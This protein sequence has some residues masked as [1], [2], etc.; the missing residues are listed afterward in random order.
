[1]FLNLSV[2]GNREMLEL[3]RVFRLVTYIL[4][5]VK[6]QELHDSPSMLL[7]VEKS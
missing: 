5:K 2:A 6:P 1:V 7:L 4:L 3:S